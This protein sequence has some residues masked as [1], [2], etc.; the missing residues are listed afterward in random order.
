MKEDIIELSDEDVEALL[1]KDDNDIA[2]KIVWGVA[3]TVLFS[4]AV[5]VLN[6]LFI[7]K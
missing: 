5:V 3:S 6:L 2:L 1:V 7:D 4:V